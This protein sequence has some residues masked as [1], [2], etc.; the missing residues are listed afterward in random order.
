[1]TALKRKA[2]DEGVTLKELLAE[3]LDREL[4]S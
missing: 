1:M 2:L 4:S 3:M